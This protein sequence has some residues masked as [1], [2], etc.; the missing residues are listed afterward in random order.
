MNANRK[1]CSASQ[2]GMKLNAVV[3]VSLIIILSA[4]CKKS[5]DPAN[6]IASQVAGTYGGAVPPGIL[7]GTLIISRQSDT[8]V[9]LDLNGTLYENAAVSDGGGGKYNISLTTGTTTISGTVSGNIFDCYFNQLQF[10]GV[11][12]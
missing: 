9:N 1:S 2:T 8:R 6:D 4:G 10:Y 11:K 12:Q 3:F 5:S 7:S